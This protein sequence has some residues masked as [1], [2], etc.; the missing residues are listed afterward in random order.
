MRNMLECSYRS[1]VGPFVNVEGGYPIA[2]WDVYAFTISTPDEARKAVN[3]LIDLGADMIKTAFE[4]GY[5]FSQSGWPLLSPDTARALVEAAHE[6]GKIETAQVS[7]ARDLP[8]AL[9]AGQR[10]QTDV[11][12]WDDAHADYSFHNQ[13]WGPIL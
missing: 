12:S 1:S 3:Q 13:E 7:S 10:D 8:R 2:F 11:G 5:A 4:T 9:D 6:R